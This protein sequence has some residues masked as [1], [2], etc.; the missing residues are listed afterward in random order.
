MTDQE[1]ELALQKNRDE[2]EKEIN[3]IVD[4]TIAYVDENREA[5]A[6][7]AY[8]KVMSEKCWLE[9]LLDF[10]DKIVGKFSRK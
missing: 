5:W 2:Y 8:Q 6:E 3:E 10:W 1:L 9:K 7:A 4:E